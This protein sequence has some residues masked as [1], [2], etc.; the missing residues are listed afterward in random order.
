M[1][2]TVWKPTCERFVAF[3]DILGFENTVIRE[4]H[5]DVHKFMKRLSKCVRAI[6]N[7]TRKYKD[8]IIT[9][10]NLAIVE[11]RPLFFS[12]SILLTAPDDSEDSLFN[13]WF[14]SA[15]LL[16]HSI[17]SQIPIKGALAH[18]FQT[19]FSSF[20]VAGILDTS[21]N[22]LDGRAYPRQVDSDG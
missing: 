9:D 2:T 6:E 20:R 5:E 1:K 17:G 19:W 14:N 8:T 3:F 15:F 22:V 4:K 16:C 10:Y 11:I 13:L 21:Y 12:D 18:G 7:N